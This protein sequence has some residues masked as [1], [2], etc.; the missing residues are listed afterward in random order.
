MKN[1]INLFFGKEFLW[2]YGFIFVL[3]FLVGRFFLAG[4]ESTFSSIM[5]FMLL[6]LIFCVFFD[7][8]NLGG[9]LKGSYI[10]WLVIGLLVYVCVG[11]F[12]VSE[13]SSYY[14]RV[15]VIL[16]FV[17]VVA[18]L[19]SEE[20]LFEK[21]LSFAATV[22]GFVALITLFKVFFFDG[23]SVN[24]RKD[25]LTGGGE[26]FEFGNNIVAALNYSFF[27]VVAFWLSMSCKGRYRFF[28]FSVF[29]IISLFVFLTF[30]RSAYLS[31]CIAIFSMIALKARWKGVLA[32]FTGAFLL[33]AIISFLFWDYVVYEF[34]K[35]GLSGRNYIWDVI[36]DRLGSDWFFG[37]G[38]A[39]EWG[40]IIFP[41]GFIAK[42]AHSVYVEILYKYG[43]FGLLMFIGII[44]GAAYV[45]FKNRRENVCLLWF[46]VV[47]S[48]SVVM[49]VEMRDIINSPNRLWLWFW[50]PVGVAVYYS[51]L[52]KRNVSS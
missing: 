21:V 38:I 47:T 16:I 6:P 5:R 1:K 35:R 46:G 26:I 27:A 4:N 44:L 39:G 13:D 28:W 7:I 10:Y 2:W 32:F 45:F 19:A 33:I 29:C 17:S 36:I 24:H 42:N 20:N 18:V 48:V 31:I 41:H 49:L 23:Y 51:C 50:M 15:L 40:E 37:K 25:L 30:A 9:M 22:A 11:V 3:F 52:E 12:L 43:L 14:R 34:F 8:K